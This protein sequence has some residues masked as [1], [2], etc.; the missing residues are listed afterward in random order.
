M[1]TSYTPTTYFDSPDRSNEQELQRDKQLINNQ[2]LILQL[3]EGYPSLAVILNRNRQIVAYNGKAADLLFADQSGE[4][5]GRRLGEALKCIHATEMPAGCGT[6]IFCTECGAGKCS[7][8][9]NE[10]G[11]SCSEECRITTEHNS[12]ESS[13]DLRVFTSNL[14]ISGENFILFSI[15]DIKDEKR[16]K[17]LEKI[18]FHD[19][20]N[21]ATAIQ[22]VSEILNSTDKIEEINEFSGMLLN[23]SHQLISE[24]QTQRDLLNAEQGILSINPE[25]KSVNEILSRAYDLYKETDLSKE[26]KYIYEYLEK[27]VYLKTDIVLLVRSLGNLI[28]NAL[29]ASKKTESIKIYCDVEEDSILF[30]VQNDAVIPEQIQLQL[31]QRSFST[32]EANGR[33]I[34]TYSVKLLTE[35]YLNGSVAFI[36]NTKVGTIFTIRIPFNTKF[37][38]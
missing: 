5:Y 10:T 6:S 20:L 4:I 37:Y 19:V 17:I 18:F 21:T 34:G 7:K 35:Q 29:E 25:R 9:T 30:N 15:E 23:S 12:A 14:R 22:G 33:G 38:N 32:K 26:K 13:L 27:D 24:I 1:N 36:S 28:K 8:K 31:F 3:L 2:P 11:A 16:R